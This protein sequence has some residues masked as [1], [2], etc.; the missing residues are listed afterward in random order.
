MKVEGRC[1]CGTIEYETQVLPGTTTVC[2]G[3]DCRAQSGSAFRAS[4]A[5]LAAGFRR[6]KDTLVKS[7]GA[8]YACALENPRS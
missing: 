6:V 1:Y 8:L 3:A 7:A 5:A 4:I 2:H